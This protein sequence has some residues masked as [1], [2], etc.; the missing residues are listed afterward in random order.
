MMTAFYDPEKGHHFIQHMSNDY[1][2]RWCLNNNFTHFKLVDVDDEIFLKL[3]RKYEGA[4]TTHTL[5]DNM[6]SFVG[7]NP[8][9][10]NI[11][12]DMIEITCITAYQWLSRSRF[13]T[14]HMVELNSQ[15]VARKTY[16]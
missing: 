8:D 13:C 11:R 4:L 6:K 2:E 15:R 1:I 12:P 14:D 16:N 3:V 5:F 9:W 7:N 10:E